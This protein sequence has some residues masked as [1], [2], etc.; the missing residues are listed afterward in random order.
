M[1]DINEIEHER[2]SEGF[3]PSFTHDHKSDASKYPVIRN[4]VEA[5]AKMDDLINA[6]TQNASDDIVYHFPT[7][8]NHLPEYDKENNRVKTFPKEFA[9]ADWD[10]C[11]AGS[12]AVHF[13]RSF[14]VDA[15][16]H[17]YV[18][19][20]NLYDKVKE[21]TGLNFDA[22]SERDL[23]AFIN[24]N[25]NIR[26]A[27]TVKNI[28]GDFTP[29]DTDI[30]FLNSPVNHRMVLPGLDFVHTKA[31][32]PEDLILNFDLPCC[33]AA[34]NSKYDFWISASC[35]VALF[36][37]SYYLP[38]YL[39]DEA[40]FNDILRVHRVKDCLDKNEKYLFSRIGKR[41]KKYQARG[42][43]CQWL[44]TEQ[45]QPW[46]LNRFHYGWEKTV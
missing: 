10:W 43:K 34:F 29:N 40:K 8:Y 44:V 9:E 27:L 11:V 35:L 3:K 15:N 21:V 42:F 4:F 17:R 23:K 7:L 33:R 41:V 37:G 1:K 22:V 30:F 45:V 28:H 38:Y 46:I 2:R 12:K 31:K 26:S 13:A 20:S 14:L 32:S 19:S 25:P 6:V 39:Q 18:G 36:T 24:N 5:V 16:N